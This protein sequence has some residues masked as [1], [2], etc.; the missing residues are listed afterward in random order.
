MVKIEL[1]GNLGAPAVVRTGNDGKQY[2]AFQ[3]AVSYG[4]NQTQWFG[5]LTPRRERMEPFLTK[6]AKIFVRGDLSVSF[7]TLQ[8]GRQVVDFDIFAKELELVG[9]KTDNTEQN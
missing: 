1:I 4:S 5:I 9:A 3:V 8:D 6:G 2:N 7:K